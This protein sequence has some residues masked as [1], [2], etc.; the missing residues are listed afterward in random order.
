MKTTK[1]CCESMQYHLE[2]KCDIHKDAFECPDNLIFKSKKNKD[3]G[4]II[5]DGGN[6]FITIKFCPWCGKKLT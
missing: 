6:S 4:I 2:Y 3:Y 5:H 1:F